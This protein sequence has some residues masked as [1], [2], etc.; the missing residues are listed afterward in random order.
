M[1]GVGNIFCYVK[2]SFCSRNGLWEDAS[3]TL[4]RIL[5]LE[6]PVTISPSSPTFISANTPE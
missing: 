3:C 4:L 5:F 6:A 1:I 2:D